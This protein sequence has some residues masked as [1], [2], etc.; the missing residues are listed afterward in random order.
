MALPTELTEAVAEAR[1]RESGEFDV[2]RRAQLVAVTRRTL[3][4][5][6]KH[7]LSTAEAV[8]ALVSSHR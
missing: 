1:D 7:Q 5:W 4:A 6:L 2:G 8:S 3:E